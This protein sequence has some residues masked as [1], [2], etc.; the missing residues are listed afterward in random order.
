MA[1]FDNITLVVAFCSTFLIVIL[2]FH[3]EKKYN[4]QFLLL[5]F[6]NFTLVS[7]AQYLLISESDLLIYAGFFI[8][9]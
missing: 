7:W 5:T 4:S 6:L 1:F 9:P 2:F 8:L 3:R